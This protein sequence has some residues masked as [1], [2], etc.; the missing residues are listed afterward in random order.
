MK[1]IITIMGNCRQIQEKINPILISGAL[2][3]IIYLFVNNN[4]NCYVNRSYV[5]QI[6]HIANNKA[7]L[8]SC[9]GTMYFP[10]WNIHQ[11][12][13]LP[14]I[15]INNYKLDCEKYINKTITYFPSDIYPKYMGPNG[16]YYKGKYFNQTKYITYKQTKPF[17]FLEL[18]IFQPCINA[19]DYDEIK[20]IEQKY[21]PIW[22]EMEE[23][24]SGTVKEY[25]NIKQKNVIIIV[26][27]IAIISFYIILLIIGKISSKNKKTYQPIINTI[28]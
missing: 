4:M 17:I 18:Q 15:V 27:L 13:E 11:L 28:N 9:N 1:S 23:Y 3:A 6:S 22:R 12:I 19:M 2:I 5:N 24:I 10:K 20:N 8:V 14:M 26:T 7:I 21:V 25:D 16:L